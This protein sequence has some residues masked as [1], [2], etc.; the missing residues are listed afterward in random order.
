M[1]HKRN[2]VGSVL[3]LA[4]ARRVEGSAQL[5][6]GGLVQEHERSL[7]AW[8]AEWGALSDALAYTGG[9]AAALRGVLEGLE[10]DAD[11]MGTNLE[12]TGGAIMSE[13]LTHLLTRK[14]GN[15][16]ARA[17]VAAATGSLR[18]GLAGQLSPEELDEALDPATYLGAAGAFVDRALAFYRESS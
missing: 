18:S 13:R 3:T 6:L 12:A 8:Q 15:E 10:V 5:L 4:C 7:G 14:V 17:A 1:P 2:P 16:Q 11:R 9:A